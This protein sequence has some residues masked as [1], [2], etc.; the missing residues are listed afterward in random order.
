MKFLT[1]LNSRNPFTK[2]FKQPIGPTNID[3]FRVK[4]ESSYYV[5]RRYLYSLKEVSGKPLWMT[6]RKTF[7]IGF[8]TTI[9]S[10]IWI[11]R[12]LFINNFKY[13]LTYKFSQDSIE[14]LFGHIRGT[15]GC[16]NNPNCLQFRYAIRSLLLH[17]SIKT[18]SGNCTLLIPS[19]DSLFSLKLKYKR[20]GEQQDTVITIDDI[21]SC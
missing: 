12:N 14:L 11:S 8:A 5:D 10:I 3:F 17:N 20:T 21:F 7:I 15:Y 19:N 4:D 13:V 2:G 9:K 16:N 6:R 18:S 1:F